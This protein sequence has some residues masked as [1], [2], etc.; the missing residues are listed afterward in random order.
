[1]NSTEFSLKVQPAKDIKIEHDSSEGTILDGAEETEIQVRLTNDR[2]IH[3]RDVQVT[4]TIDPRLHV[5]GVHAKKLKL[6]GDEETQVYSYRIKA[7]VVHNKTEYNITTTV[8]FFDK[9]LKQQMNYSKTT[10]ITVRPMRPDLDIDITLDKPD[11]IY[12][13][14][15]LPVEYTFTNSEELEV[16]RDITI[17]FPIQEEIDLLGPKT[18]FIDKLD[19]GE[20][21]ILKDLTY[22]R[23]KIYRKNLQIN[24]I[25]TG[26]FDNYG[27]MFQENTTVDKLEVEKAVLNGPSIFLSTETTNESINV[28]AEVRVRIRIINN[29]TDAAD[30]SIQQGGKMW[31]TSVGAGSTS[32][33]DYTV[34]Y[35]QEGNYTIPDPY[36]SFDFQGIQA[37]TKGTGADVRVEMMRGPGPVEEEEVV[38]EKEPEKEKEKEEMS[39]EEYERI[40]QESFVKRMIRY[41]ITGA[42]V[43]ILLVVI[44]FYIRYQK[45]RSPTHPFIKE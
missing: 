45:K 35:D 8:S 34:R 43:I 22:F 28:S 10:K 1:V 13:G 36:A 32:Y 20:K 17:H 3:L 31:N 27:N 23:P 37:H 2:L 42:V 21:F 9:D 30:L 44:I 25:L 19:P 38:V 11:D 29:G 6:L 15:I 39:F 24:D 4:D 33:I 12:A 5:E 40:Q 16:I 41:S 18:F 26:Y 7:P 14:T